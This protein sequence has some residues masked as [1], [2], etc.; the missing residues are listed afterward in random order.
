M[1]TAMHLFRKQAEPWRELAELHLKKV[2][3]EVKVFVDGAFEHVVGPVDSN[4]TT[5]A[6]LST[7]VDDFFDERERVLSRKLEELL[8]PFTE[9]Y[10]MQHDG[11]LR[12][13]VERRAAEQQQR[14]AAPGGGRDRHLQVSTVSAPA[15]NDD[16]DDDAGPEHIVNT[17]Q[18]LYDMALQTFTDNLTNLA[19]ESCLVQELPG[20]FTARLVND[21]DGETLAELAGEP[22]EARGDRA[23]LREEME[24][25]TQGLER[26]RRYKPRAVARFPPSARSG[27]KKQQGY[28]SEQAKSETT[29]PS[30]L[31]SK[32]ITTPPSDDGQGSEEKSIAK[33]PS[34]QQQGG[35]K[36][37]EATDGS[38]TTEQ[39]SVPRD[40]AGKRPVEPVISEP[41]LDSAQD[42]FRLGPTRTD[43]P[44]F[45]FAPTAQSGGLFGRAAPS[46]APADTKAAKTG[47][48]FGAK[49]P[50]STGPPDQPAATGGIFNV[51]GRPPPP[52]PTIYFGAPTQNKSPFGP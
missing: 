6:I 3:E 25:L 19:V 5:R 17:M 37:G 48:M 11:D 42:G 51:A 2:T 10:A 40:P 26:C 46:P 24:Q 22:E 27:S 18:A 41:A 7:F 45:S 34:D 28:A 1:D 23:L 49:P 12:S 29:S 38:K 20:I 32:T 33:R 35:G 15:G 14:A 50:T 47:V 13:A 21:M 9:G 52:P 31:A 44:M 16:D 30:S 43:T 4:R 8:R 36:G 39:A